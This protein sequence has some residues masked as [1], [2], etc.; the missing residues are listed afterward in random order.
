[1]SPR[2]LF[3]A[4]CPGGQACF[5]AEFPGA[6]TTF[7]AEFPFFWRPNCG[8]GL[9]SWGL[10]CGSAGFVARTWGF[11]PG[12][13]GFTPGLA[14]G[15]AGLVVGTAGLTAKPGLVLGTAGLEPA[16]LGNFFVGKMGFSVAEELE[17][18]LN[19]STG[20][21]LTG[22]RVDTEGIADTGLSSVFSASLLL[23]CWTGFRK[24][25]LGFVSI[26]SFCWEF[27]ASLDFFGNVGLCPLK[28]VLK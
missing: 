6:R 20:L 15:T 19:L 24:G 27:S 4:G 7:V 16:V 21:E 8:V 3:S 11:V 17:E 28:D 2:S 1:M 13:W 23:F 25:T 26:A 10:F 9:L 5:G 12:T 22:L 14:L 18:F